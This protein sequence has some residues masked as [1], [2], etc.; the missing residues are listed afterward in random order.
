MRRVLLLTALAFPL[1]AAAPDSFRFAFLGD[2][3]GDVQPGVYEEVWKQMTSSKP[4]FVVCSG[5][6][7]EGGNDAAADSEWRQFLR[8]LEPFQKTPL[9]LA[10]GNHD[11]WSAASEQLYERH[12]GHPRHYSFDY[13]QA[14]F[15]ILDDSRAD[16]LAP[17]ELAFLEADLKAHVSQPLKIVVSHRP[18]WLL[19]VAMRNP[20]FPLHRLVK[21][22]GVQY[23][24]AGHIH[25]MLRFELGGVT[26]VSLPSAGGHLRLTGAYQDGWF[27]GYSFIH[28][29]GTNLDWEIHSTDGRASRLAD[30][31]MTG[32]VKK[33][34]AQPH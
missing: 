33:T 9:Y 14:H 6:S 23:V 31:G 3:T 15:T 34:A 10:P 27:F 17:A 4:A 1:I 13:R 24:V 2:R 29:E 22:F 32:L 20:D 16:E 12:S 8:V 5:D 26:Y 28:A 7:I 11:I 25:Q 19:N 21:Q 18:S 30:W